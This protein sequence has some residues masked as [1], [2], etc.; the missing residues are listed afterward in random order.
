MYPVTSLTEASKKFEEL[1]QA[2]SVQIFI[3]NG[4]RTIKKLR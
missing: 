3:K 2:G 4:N 1:R